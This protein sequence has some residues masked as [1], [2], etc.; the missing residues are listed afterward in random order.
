MAET[1]LGV[2]AEA[3]GDGDAERVE[4]NISIGLLVSCKGAIA[5]TDAGA[6]EVF[7][8]SP[9]IS[10]IDDG[11]AGV[12]WELRGSAGDSSLEAP[13][14]SARRYRVDCCCVAV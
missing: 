6:I 7:P 3:E 14:M 8:K 5:A 11:G 9:I 2:E 4:A 10:C 13:N 12:E 1:G